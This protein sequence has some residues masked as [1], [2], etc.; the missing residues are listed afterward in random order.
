MLRQTSC[1][2]ASTNLVQEFE[3]NVSISFRVRFAELISARNVNLDLLLILKMC[4]LT[5]G[6]Y[7]VML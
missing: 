5:V 2:E 3:I 6:D 4:K 1:F 7:L